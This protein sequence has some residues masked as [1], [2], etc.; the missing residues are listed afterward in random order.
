MIENDWNQ[1]KYILPKRAIQPHGWV[2]RISQ[3]GLSVLHM[4]RPGLTLDRR[5]VYKADSLPRDWRDS[6]KSLGIDNFCSVLVGLGLDN[7]KFSSLKE[8]QSRQLKNSG[9]QKV[10]VSTNFNFNF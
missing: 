3:Y 8:S 2:L 9:S 6:R 10:S 4:Q 7:P 5:G 1:D